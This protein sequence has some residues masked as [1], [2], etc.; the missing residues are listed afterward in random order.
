ML[1]VGVD[2]EFDA[3]G[4]AQSGRTLAGPVGVAV[5][6]TCTACS[7]VYARNFPSVQIPKR[8]RVDQLSPPF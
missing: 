2:G 7:E 8:N 4:Y 6:W 3:Q 1:Q 5:I